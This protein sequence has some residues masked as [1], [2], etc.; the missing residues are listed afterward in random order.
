MQIHLTFIKKWPID[1]M[2]YFFHFEYIYKISN[3]TENKQIYWLRLWLKG[4]R[5]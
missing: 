2:A 3:E 5:R 1:G 4:K